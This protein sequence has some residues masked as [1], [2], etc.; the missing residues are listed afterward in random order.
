VYKCT[1]LSRLNA[2]DGM[3]TPLAQAEY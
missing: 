2:A 3:A 1:P